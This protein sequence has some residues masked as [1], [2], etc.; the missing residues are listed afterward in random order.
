MFLAGRTHYNEGEIHRAEARPMKFVLCENY[1]EA[2][3]RAAEMAAG[4]IREKTGYD[5]LQEGNVRSL[6]AF[7]WLRSASETR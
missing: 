7:I 3:E 2:M 1:D 6:M 4:L 5:A